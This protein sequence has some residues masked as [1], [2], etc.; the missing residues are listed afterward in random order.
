MAP[1]A[2]PFY[3]SL[4]HTQHL[5]DAGYSMLT[6]AIWYSHSGC[7]LTGVPAAFTIPPLP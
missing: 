4:A 5:K 6:A 1:A 3:P 7:P 2:N